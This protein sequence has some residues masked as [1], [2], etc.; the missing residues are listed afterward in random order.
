[1][2]Y[3]LSTMYTVKDNDRIIQ[4]NR[5]REGSPYGSQK[6]WNQVNNAYNQVRRRSR[7]WESLKGEETFQENGQGGENFHVV[8][9]T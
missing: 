3:K 2:G 4:L 9:N 6:N 8:Y 5:C 1:M 7:C